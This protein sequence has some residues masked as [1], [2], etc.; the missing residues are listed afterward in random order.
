ML[1]QVLRLLMHDGGCASLE[2]ERRREEPAPDAA[3]A[4][5][6]GSTSA[7]GYGPAPPASSNVSRA[8]SGTLDDWALWRERT[9][10]TGLALL[11]EAL[12]RDGA[13]VH[14]V[15]S[16]HIGPPVTLLSDLLLQSE[17]AVGAIVSYAGYSQDARIQARVP[18]AV[19]PPSLA[20]SACITPVCPPPPNTLPPPP[21]FAL[22]AAYMMPC[23]ACLSVLLHA[24]TQ[25]W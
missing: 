9:V 3:A 10:T 23:C 2:R 6:A 8:A 17:G 21:H 22:V 20:R 15:R 5:A 12:Q 13:F 24:S 7:P 1:D 11:D 4:S 25:R 18:A 16:S 14:A 19:F